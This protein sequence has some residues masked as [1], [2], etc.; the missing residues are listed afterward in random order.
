MSIHFIEVIL[1]LLGTI[2]IFVSLIIQRRARP[3]ENLEKIIDN[4]ILQINEDNQ[5]LLK[6]LK[7]T[8]QDKLTRMDEKISLLEQRISQFESFHIEHKSLPLEH[9][10]YEKILQMHQ[11]GK[12]IDEIAKSLNVG[13]GEIELILDLA[14]KGFHYA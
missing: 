14:K 11:E 5:A 4:F 9:S 7:K 3:E 12:T 10:K 2:V 8:S 6:R 1:L 13:H